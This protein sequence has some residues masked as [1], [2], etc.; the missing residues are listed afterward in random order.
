MA[1]MKKA[2]A[3]PVAKKAAPS[4]IQQIAKRF[5][6]TAREARDIATAVGTVGKA[7]QQN[8]GFYGS[9]A[10]SNLKTQVKETAK[11]AVTGK[12]GTESNQ[13]RSYKTTP[14]QGLRS[15]MYQGLSRDKAK[16]KPGTSVTKTISDYEK[17]LKS[18]KKK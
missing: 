15:A 12:K 14:T 7:V 5:N 4:T 6:I 3:K 2:A 1:Q 13:I 10:V 9:D 18:K 11:A 16:N 17:L 8:R